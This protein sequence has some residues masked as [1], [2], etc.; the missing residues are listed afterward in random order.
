MSQPISQ[1]ILER[2]AW[3]NTS[4]HYCGYQCTPMSQPIFQSILDPSAW[5]NSSTLYSGYQCTPHDPAY[6][7]V[8]SWRICLIQHWHTL[9]SISVY[10][11]WPSLY[12]SP[13]STHLSDTT[14]AH[15][16]VDIT[17]HP[18]AHPISQSILDLSACY[19]TSTHYCGYQ[20]TPH[21][22]AYIPVHSQPICL[23]QQ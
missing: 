15:I 16:T 10:T 13:F 8:H 9:L 22:P 3:Y 17:A 1:S 12:P 7:P 14:V 20:C 21:V 23:I 4:T 5:Y 6:I 19:N 11:P 18:M 2:S